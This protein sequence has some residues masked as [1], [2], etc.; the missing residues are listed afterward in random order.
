MCQAACALLVVPF[1]TMPSPTL[2]LLCTLCCVQWL[3]VGL[4]AGAPPASIACPSLLADAK[5]D[6]VDEV[7]WWVVYK[8]PGSGNFYLIQA[9][10]ESSDPP[11]NKHFDDVFKN[12]VLLYTDKLYNEDFL[13]ATLD[14]FID[15]EN[16]CPQVRLF[17]LSTRLSS[18]YSLSTLLSHLPNYFVSF[19][20][21]ARRGRERRGK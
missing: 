9:G 2:A 13:S 17:S 6:Q 18:L 1:L 19:L 5:S 14:T 16:D 15:E 8:V 20:L 4:I 12:R 11:I 10:S 21:L 3:W 7:D